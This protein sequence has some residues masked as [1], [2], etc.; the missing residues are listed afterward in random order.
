MPLPPAHVTPP[1]DCLSTTLTRVIQGC[2]QPELI[3]LFKVLALA[4]GMRITSQ[5]LQSLQLGGTQLPHRFACTTTSCAPYAAVPEN[6]MPA[7]AVCVGRPQRLAPGSEGQM[8]K[9]HFHGSLNMF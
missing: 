1:L 2:A 5:I 8:N 4:P 3:S 9:H 7:A 6:C